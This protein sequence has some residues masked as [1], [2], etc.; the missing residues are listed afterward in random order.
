MSLAVIEHS[1][2]V[3]TFWPPESVPMGLVAILPFS[4]KAPRNDLPVCSSISIPD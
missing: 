2:Y 1:D 4:P 3:H